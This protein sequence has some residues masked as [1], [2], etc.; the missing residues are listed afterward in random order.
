MKPLLVVDS[1]ALSWAMM[2]QEQ[3]TGV[4]KVGIT[5]HDKNDVRTGFSLFI[6]SPN[7]SS[8]GLVATAAPSSADAP[9]NRIPNSFMAA[10]ATICLLRWI[11]SSRT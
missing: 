1:A 8:A 4:C 10:E 7:M 2:S 5:E 9:V 6:A 3:R 11:N